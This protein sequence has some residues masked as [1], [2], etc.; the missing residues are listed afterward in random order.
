MR[1]QLQYLIEMA[2]RPNITLQVLP[3]STAAHVNPVSPFT[4]QWYLTTFVLRR[5]G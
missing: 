1:G 2:E 5:T 3:F 4:I